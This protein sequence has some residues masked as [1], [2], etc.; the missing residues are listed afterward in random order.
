LNKRVAG[1]K[2]GVIGTGSLGSSHARIYSSCEHI[3]AL[4]LYDRVNDRAERV[5]GEFGGVCCSTMEELLSHCDLISI[6]TPATNHHESVLAAF[7]RGV[8]VLVEKPLASSSTEG[9]EMVHAAD[10]EGCVFQVGHIERF[11]GAF[12]AASKLVDNPMFI[13]IHRLGMFT[14]RG[15]DVSVVVD[16]MIHDL[17]LVM[18]VLDGQEIV[19][20]SASGAEVL[21]GSPDIVNARL[22]FENGCVANITASRISLEQLRK[23][24][25]FQENL[26]VSA[27]LRTKEVE[28]YRK[29]KDWT[30]GKIDSDPFSFVESIPVRISTYEPLALEIQSFID[31]VK[32]KSVPSVSGEEG[33]RAL[34][35]AER[36]LESIQ[37][38]GRMV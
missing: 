18:H 13:E 1:L 9:E 35:A 28:A 20:L 16:L 15:T 19:E 36:V 21:S 26:Y 6:C 10:R 22:K 5:A 29:R 8:H 24:R 23:I 32:G 4:F 37:N 27:D 7:E 12:E 11:N 2:A 38:S 33:L 14:P 34:L 31:T 30:N 17:D 25:F 3:E